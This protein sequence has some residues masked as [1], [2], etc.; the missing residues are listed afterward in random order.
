MCVFAEKCLELETKYEAI[1]FHQDNAGPH[2][3]RQFRN[4]LA[5]SGWEVLPHKNYSTPLASSVYNFFQFMPNIHTEIR[6][7]SEQS[8]KNWSDAY[9]DGSVLLG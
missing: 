8:M 9:L 7:T 5:N 2:V 4:S 3:A 1:I 6:F